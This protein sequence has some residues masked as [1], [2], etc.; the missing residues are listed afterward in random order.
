M[1]P[2]TGI[3]CAHCSFIAVLVVGGLRGG[4]VIIDVNGEGRCGGLAFGNDRPIKP[5]FGNEIPTIVRA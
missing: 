5:L 2:A 3:I 4:I 1:I